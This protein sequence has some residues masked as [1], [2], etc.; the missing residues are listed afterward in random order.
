MKKILLT[1][2]I[3]L[4]FGIAHSQN[5]ND[6]KITFKYI[7][8]P[9]IKIDD[10]FTNYQILVEHDYNQANEDSLALFQARKDLAVVEFQRKI[11]LYQTSRDSLDKIHLRK[12]STWQK[13]VNSGLTKPDGSVLDKPFPPNYPAQPAYPNIK[14][15][16]L[17]K[18]YT[19]QNVKQRVALAGFE[20]G[21]GGIQITF[22][23]LP[24]QNISIVK[25]KK[26]T[27]SSTKYSYSARYT[28]PIVVTVAS[29]TQGTLLETTMFTSAK[30][31]KMSDQKSE[32]DHQIYMLERKDEFYDKLELY[33]RN[34]AFSDVNNVL[35]NKFGFVN[36]SR[37]TEVYSVKSFKNYDYT[38]VTQSY[39]LAVQAL[40]TVSAD[41]DRDGAMDKLDEAIDA[42]KLILEESSL[43]DKKTR[44]NAKVT[45]MLQCNL[46]E[47]LAWQGE[48]DKADATV[49]IAKNSGEGKAKRHC[50]SVTSFYAD[51]RKRWDAH[52]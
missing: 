37:R 51:Q 18:A 12:L 9:L 27:G 15:P 10:Q 17:H 8:L 1:A 5:I 47:L 14:A 29:P 50:K 45:A 33:A 42:I 23:L 13:N 4:G 52:Y 21:L 19:N 35:N 16:H 31:Y 3:L 40:Q 46:A 26:G 43:S 39:T 7:Q 25:S 41:R 32:Y 30:S 20:D 38:D 36:K 28:L 11:V 34:A 6:N 24:I 22:K 2:T 48:Y 44:I 49:N